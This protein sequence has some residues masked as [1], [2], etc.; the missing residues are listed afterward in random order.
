M[1]PGFIETNIREAAKASRTTTN[2]LWGDWGAALDAATAGR[3]R[4][5]VPVEQYTQQLVNMALQPQLPR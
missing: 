2:S 1:A 5:A 3:L 4:H